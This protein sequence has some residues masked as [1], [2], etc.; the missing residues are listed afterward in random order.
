M[1]VVHQLTLMVRKIW[2]DHQALLHYLQQQRFHVNAFLND[3]EHVC[4][5][6]KLQKSVFFSL[7]YNGDGPY[8][9]L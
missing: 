3:S 9:D 2:A 8:H 5:N 1:S 4:S 6:P 7:R